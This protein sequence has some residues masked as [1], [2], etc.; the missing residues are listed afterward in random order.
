MEIEGMLSKGRTITTI[1]GR[2]RTFYGRWGDE[3][4][5]EATAFIPQSTVADHVYGAIQKEL[6]IKG[7]LIEIHKWCKRNDS[8]L[9]Q[10]AH[11]SVVLDIPPNRVNDIAPDVIRLFRRPMVINGHEFTIPVDVKHGDRWGELK[12]LKVA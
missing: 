2:K 7:G 5:K 11:D 12:K 8:L 4:F 1:Y 10:T 6:G 3:I 9:I